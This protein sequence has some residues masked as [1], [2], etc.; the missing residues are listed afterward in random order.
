MSIETR[1]GPMSR[2]FRTFIKK[3][4][5]MAKH[6]KDLKDLR[7]LR[8]RAG[9]RH[10]GPTDLKRTRDGFF[11]SPLSVVCARLITNRSDQASL[12]YRAWRANDS[13]G[14]ALALR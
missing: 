5:D 14:Q 4:A 8:G 12:T 2:A 3:R 6:I 9:Y 7:L 10:S 11:R 13:E 1:D